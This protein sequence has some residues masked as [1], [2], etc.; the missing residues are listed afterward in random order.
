MGLQ[1][2]PLRKTAKRAQ[3]IS[4]LFSCPKSSFGF[5][6]NIQ[7]KKKKIFFGQHNISY[8]FM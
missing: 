2:Q 7:Q 5:F 6:S 4:V 1:D 8:D 3:W